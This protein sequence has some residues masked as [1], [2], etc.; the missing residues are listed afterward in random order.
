MLNF[1]TPDDSSPLVLVSCQW[2]R[3]A[4]LVGDLLISMG[5]R[6]HG[7]DRLQEAY[8]ILAADG[9]DLILADSDGGIE[10]LATLLE[11]LDH[12]P[13][14]NDLPLVL[15]AN[16]D[17]LSALKGLTARR[18]NAMILAKPMGREQLAAA[19]ESGLRLRARQRQIRTLVAE[20]SA[21]NDRL[22]SANL[23]LEQ[24]Q[25]ESH[26]E[27]QR[28]TRFLAAISHDIRTPVN[29]LV[30]SCQLLRAIGQ[31][32]PSAT[33]PVG[34][35]DDL[36][37][38]LMT[39][40]SALAELVNDL[41]N[42]ARHD[43][44]KLEYVESTFKLGELLGTTVDGMRPLA[45]QKGLALILTDT[46]AELVFQTDRVKLTR[47]LQ[48]LIANAI[49]FTDHGEVRVATRVPPAALD[50]E[51][52]VHDTGVGIAESLR[53]GIFDEFTQLR[54]PERDRT[55]GTGLGLA[56]CR[57]L[58]S[59]LG[60]TIEV[61]TPPGVKGSTFRV[62]LP[63]AR[64]L[65]RTGSDPRGVTPSFGT[66]APVNGHR[67]AG[68]VLVVE[69]H[70]PSRILLQRLLRRTGLTVRTAENGAEALQAIHEARPDLVLM[71][72]M[73]P[74]LGGLETL[75]TLRA[76]PSLADL[77]VVI[78]T[79]D[80]GGGTAANLQVEG[81]SSLLSKPVEVET[82]YEVLDRYLP[83]P[84]ATI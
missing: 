60:G 78:L 19:I 9:I 1:A 10:P 29:A 41:L 81:A 71:D 20:V 46:S 77:T 58:V 39:N 36:T 57:R 30:L 5:A 16:S 33:I 28:K 59:A 42:I 69:D 53:E 6:A 84:N 15:L 44:G 61:V 3:D 51:I 11:L 2:E 49:K 79:G 82:L 4:E 73:M 26:E 40:A 63:T 62:T 52:E 31:A 54:N 43:Q 47:V 70:E 13:D 38:A 7:F 22:A 65:S 12:L 27:A 32:S 8:D 25:A 48:N 55:K 24:R 14:R 72:L 75:Q 67:Y 80:L 74:V 18:F 17:D 66:S 21:S 56:I 34:D 76:E 35:I 68:D 83:T 64:V 45:E 23:A 37:G 50:I